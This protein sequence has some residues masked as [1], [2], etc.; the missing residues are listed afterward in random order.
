MC[1]KCLS[2]YSPCCMQLS[3]RVRPRMYA[4]MHARLEFY[5]GR[6]LTMRWPTYVCM[7]T[8]PPARPLACPPARPPACP[9]ACSHRCTHWPQASHTGHQL[10]WPAYSLTYA[11]MHA[12]TCVR[13]CVHATHACPSDIVGTRWTCIRHV[14][15]LRQD[16]LRMC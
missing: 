15:G 12:H 10:Q 13:A 11:R 4:H 9:P 1:H 16:V 6:R 3:M 7:P 2:T 5:M 14:L 8:R